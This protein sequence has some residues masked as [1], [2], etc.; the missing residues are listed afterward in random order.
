MCSKLLS[1]LQI[2]KWTN[3]LL[4]WLIYV[5]KGHSPSPFLAKKGRV[6]VCPLLLKEFPPN[7]LA[8]QRV[9]SR[10]L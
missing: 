4:L 2:L 5:L 6:I 1:Q 8:W 3:Q 9:V 7:G 10:V